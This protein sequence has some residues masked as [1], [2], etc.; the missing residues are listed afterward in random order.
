MHNQIHLVPSGPTDALVRNEITEI[1]FPYLRYIEGWQLRLSYLRA[2]LST[3]PISSDEHD[4]AKRRLAELRGEV[5]ASRDYLVA[6][7]SRLPPD[8]R[9]DATLDELEQL[10]TLVRAAAGV[11]G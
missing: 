9:I 11:A 5:D 1:I 2:Q 10:L 7:T 8:D 6:E 3:H 4:L